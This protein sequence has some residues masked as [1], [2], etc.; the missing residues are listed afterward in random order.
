MAS[1]VPATRRAYDAGMPRRFASQPGLIRRLA[2]AL[3]LMGAMGPVAGAQQTFE[4]DDAD[5]WVAERPPEPGTPEAQLELAR[6]ALA[7]GDAE[8][9]EYLATQW[10]ERHPRH[11]LIPEAHLVR[12]DARQEGGDEY[13]ALFDYEYLARSFPGSEPFVT[14]LE[15]EYEIARKYARGMNRKLWGLRIIDAREEAEELLIRIQERLPGSRLA[16]QAGLELADYYFRE[17]DMA[18]AAEMYE[19]FLEN[20]PRS[21]HVDKARRRLIYAHL[22]SFKGPQ[23]DA[24]GLYEARGLLL[25]LI[26]TEPAQAQRMGAEAIITRIDESDAR[27]MLT[28]ALWYLRRDDYIAT[29]YTIRRLIRKYPGAI[30]TADALRLIPDVLD[31]LPDNVLDEAP[32]YAAL[33]SAILGTDALSPQEREHRERSK[34]ADS[35]LNHPPSRLGSP[36]ESDRP[37]DGTGEGRP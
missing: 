2:P 7:R 15:R 29:E 18:L 5:E 22:A 25:S 1:I 34:E 21:E 11:P 26:R 30:A 9:A 28:T 23:F 16:E 31:H 27:K 13:Q 12:G 20:F 6:T 4:L 36:D 8:R 14:A 3:F 24:A 32:D 19:I 33:R 37:T 17:R 35:P 10:I